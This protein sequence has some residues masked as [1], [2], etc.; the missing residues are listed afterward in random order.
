MCLVV[1]NPEKNPDDYDWGDKPSADEQFDEQ[2]N[3][4]NDH[5]PIDEENNQNVHLNAPNQKP[6]AT[7]ATGVDR[8]GPKRRQMPEDIQF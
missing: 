1:N 5:M 4:L 2:S 6:V 7:P 8:E 3:E